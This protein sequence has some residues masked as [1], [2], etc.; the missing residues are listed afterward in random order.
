MLVRLG[1]FGLIP[2]PSRWR[3]EFCDPIDASGYG[4]EAADD[5]TLVFDL[6]EQV[7]ETIQAK[8]YENLVKRG[9]AYLF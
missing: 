6:S 7:R 1:P 3:I 5:R 8:L 2:L 9:S 4:A